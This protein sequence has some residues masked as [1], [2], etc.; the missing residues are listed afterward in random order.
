MKKMHAD[1][2]ADLIRM[3]EKLGVSTHIDDSPVS[4]AIPKYSGDQLK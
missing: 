4:R 2:L 1:S 3:G